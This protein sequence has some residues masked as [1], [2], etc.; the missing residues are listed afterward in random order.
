MYAVSAF[1]D[2]L[3]LIWK[4]CVGELTGLPGTGRYVN[5]S[6]FRARPTVSIVGIYGP[7]EVIARS[8]SFKYVDG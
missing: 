2:R 3:S 4:Q 7:P 6:V 1:T 8:H 5:V